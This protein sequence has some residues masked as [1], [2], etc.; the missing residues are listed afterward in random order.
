MNNI[1]ETKTRL[2]L[3]AIVL[4]LFVGSFQS[5]KSQQLRWLRVGQLQNFIVDYGSENE[6]A[7]LANNSFIWPAQYGSNQYTSRAKGLWIGA[8]NF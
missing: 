5:A 6:L 1:N 3:L 2:T 7:P 4:I 8:T